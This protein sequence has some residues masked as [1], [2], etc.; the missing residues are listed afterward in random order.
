MPF[1][2][3]SK[4]AKMANQDKA[5]WRVLIVDDEPDIHTVTQMALKYF[6]MENK[7]IEF[8]HA[9]SGLEAQEVVAREEDIALIFLDVVM[10]TDEAGLT[11]VKWLREEEKNLITRVVLRT[12]QPGQAPEEDVIM[13][14][15]I[16]DYKQKSE[17]NSTKL[18]TA[19]VTAFRAYRDLQS[20]EKSRNYERLYR[21]GLEKVI[22][23]TSDVLERKTFKEFFGGL[24]EQVTSLIHIED[25]SILVNRIDGAGAIY[26]KDEFEI[27]AQSGGSNIEKLSDDVIS[28][29]NKAKDEKRSV[30]QDNTYIAYFPSNSKQDS[31]LYL[32]GINLVKLKDV[33]IQLLE[34]FCKN[35]G[36]AFDNLILNRE[37]LKTQEELIERLGNAV[38]SRSK[39]SGNHIK[40]MSLFS[41]II[42][43]AMKL[44]NHECE[45]L[46]QATPM[47]DVGKIATPDSVL[48]KPGRLNDDEMEIMK[49]HT[50]VGYEILKG[51]ERPILK[52]AA[53]ISQQHHEK[54]DGTGYPNGLQGEEI[55]IFARIV[56]VADV[57]DALLHKR[58]YKEPWPLE[59]VTELLISEKGKHFDPNVVD[60]LMENLDEVMEANALNTNNSNL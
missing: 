32:K 27:V 37:I 10:E 52:A 12:G 47:H 18:F 28:L 24:L 43:Q 13:K 2:L 39:E 29:F 4:K 42:A 22:A 45:I 23:S 1:S 59:R 11:F 54:Y 34:V 15:D 53:I 19:V 5:S 40:R 41:E 6:E 35:I 58:C 20:I 14:Y 60:V 44:P 51:S 25:E 38:E 36:I 33:N 3:L 48:L 17:L 57:F 26:D 50:N 56:A 7:K 46:K 49:Q 31:F 16:N 21:Q 55:H 9:Y 8:L 30:F